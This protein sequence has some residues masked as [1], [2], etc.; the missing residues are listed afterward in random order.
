MCGHDSNFLPNAAWASQATSAY[1]RELQ[2]ALVNLEPKGMCKLGNALEAAFVLLEKYRREDLGTGCNQAVM[3]VTDLVPEHEE[4]LF[5]THN[6]PELDNPS[7]TH[8]RVFTF[9]VGDW[10]QGPPREAQWMA[11]ANKGTANHL[12]KLYFLKFQ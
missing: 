4:E 9:I 11:C 1:V 6:R 12:F 8:A 3:L 10:A 5:R 2:H 7:H